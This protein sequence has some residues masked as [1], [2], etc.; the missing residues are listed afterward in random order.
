MSGDRNS[1][2][3]VFTA[4]S[5]KVAA[6]N[7]SLKDFLKIPPRWRWEDTAVSVQGTQLVAIK[8]LVGR[9]FSA[10]VAC[11]KLWASQ[12]KP[13]KRTDLFLDF[14]EVRDVEYD[15]TPGHKGSRERSRVGRVMEGTLP[16]GSVSQL[17]NWLLSSWA[18][19]LSNKNWLFSVPS[20][21][22]FKG[23]RIH[24]NSP[25]VTLYIQRDGICMHAQ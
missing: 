7:I 13:N 11:A 23:K 22:T 5:H 20:L 9:K 8:C 24:I 18:D 1:G 2:T 12:Q 3:G 16:S 4:N 14:L 10:R 21:C 25:Y 19:L 17:T 15:L 6:Q